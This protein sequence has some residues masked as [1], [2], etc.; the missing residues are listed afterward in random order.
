MQV[1]LCLL[2]C[3]NSKLVRLKES[4]SIP[5]LAKLL[6]FNSKLVRLKAVYDAITHREMKRLKFQF[7]TGSIK[8]VIPKQRTIFMRKSFNS[9]L[10]RLK[11][12][13]SYKTRHGK[14]TSFNSKLVRLKEGILQET[15]KFQRRQRF[16]SKLVRL[17]VKIGWALIPIQYLFQFQTGSIKRYIRTRIP[18]NQ[19]RVSIPNWFD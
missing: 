5:Q 8:S 17:K 12:K 11:E 4:T 10:V 7:Q 14:Q 1:L 13:A 16:N 19:R 15:P 18:R 9:K 6:S 3:F 2:R